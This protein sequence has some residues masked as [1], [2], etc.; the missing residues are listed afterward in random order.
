MINS[1]IAA[2][3]ANDKF[4]AI[5]C[6][7]FRG[8]GIKLNSVCVTPDGKVRVYDSVAGHYTTLHSMSRAAVAKARKMAGF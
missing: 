7:A 3:T 2:D 4:F 6:K 5:R 8:E 1:T